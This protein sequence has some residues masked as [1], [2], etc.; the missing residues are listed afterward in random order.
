MRRIGKLEVKEESGMTMRSLGI[1]QSDE[2]KSNKYN[3]F[4]ETQIYRLGI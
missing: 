1:A 4:K 2:D 3:L